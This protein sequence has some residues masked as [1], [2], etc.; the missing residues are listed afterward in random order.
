VGVVRGCRQGDRRRVVHVLA[1]RR[2]EPLVSALRPQL[3]GRSLMC[4]SRMRNADRLVE[5]DVLVVD[6]TRDPNWL[7]PSEMPEVPGMV[8]VFLAVGGTPVDPG[9]IEVATRT[10]LRVFVEG[11]DRQHGCW[12]DLAGAVCMELDSSPTPSLAAL[13]LERYPEWETAAHMVSAICDHPWQI[14]HPRDLIR[15]S[16]LTGPELRALCAGLGFARI[17]HF[18]T[19]VRSA[20]LG[21]LADSRVVGF[22]ARE[23]AGISDASNFRRQVRRAAPAASRTV[24]DP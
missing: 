11:L 17:E 5:G 16:P 2:D 21:V 12:S 18:I 24:V 22:A 13:V 9:W 15:A 3:A 6:L 19:L 10:S 7:R 14:R 23:I 8:R 20:A 1:P 4:W